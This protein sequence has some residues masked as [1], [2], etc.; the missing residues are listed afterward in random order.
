MEVLRKR[1]LIEV[2]DSPSDWWLIWLIEC[3]ELVTSKQKSDGVSCLSHNDSSCIVS[4]LVN[5]SV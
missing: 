2:V 4:D 1:R 3:L 5:L